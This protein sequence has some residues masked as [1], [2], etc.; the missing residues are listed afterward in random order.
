MQKKKKKS[1]EQNHP[2]AFTSFSCIQDGKL[3]KVTLVAAISQAHVPAPPPSFCCYFCA[4]VI[5]DSLQEEEVCGLQ[6]VFKI[7][8][9]DCSGTI[10]LEELARGAAQVWLPAQRRRGQGAH[11]SGEEASC[12]TGPLGPCIPVSLCHCVTVSLCHCATTKVLSDDEVKA[13]MEAVRELPRRAP[14][15]PVPVDPLAP[16]PLRCATMALCHCVTVGG[17]GRQRD[18]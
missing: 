9:T 3:E 11:G 10:S 18:D 2:Q 15:S 12:D 16:P 14:R 1:S 6:E 8:D 17:P 4:Q 5:A 13:L 7:I